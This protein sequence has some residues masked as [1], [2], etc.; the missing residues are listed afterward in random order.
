MITD[1]TTDP[2]R[3]E[4]TVRIRIVPGDRTGAWA[5]GYQEADGEIRIIS[6]V[7]A[8]KGTAALTRAEAA[9]AALTVVLQLA[10]ARGAI[11]LDLP[12]EMEL[13]RAFYDALRPFPDIRLTSPTVPGPQRA[14]ISEA[15]TAMAPPAAVV[16]LKKPAV[17]VRSLVIACDASIAANGSVAGLGW[18]VAAAD[19]DVLSCGQGTLTVA[20]RGDITLGELAAIRRGLQA[21]RAKRFPADGHGTVTVLSDSRIALSVLRKVRCG[22]PTRGVPPES[23]REAEAILALAEEHPVVFEWVK[24]H[25]GHRLNE[26]A[27]RLAVMARRNEEFK[28]TRAVADRMFQDLRAEL[29]G[30]LAA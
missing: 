27:D 21:A 30:P 26:A 28:V 5:V 15:L 24:A 8:A 6:G 14:A 29:T 1:V 7:A 25:R 4:V 16:P 13:R 23:I 12:C 22:E 9:V 10:G 3:T 11:D 19:G 17:T 18:V 20:R 2:G